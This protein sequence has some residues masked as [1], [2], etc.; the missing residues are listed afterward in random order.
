MGEAADN[1]RRYLVEVARFKARLDLRLPEGFH[2]HGAEDYLLD[3]GSPFESAPL[4]QEERAILDKAIERCPVARF[5]TGLCYFNAQMLVTADPT[6]TLI[7]CEGMAM[8]TVPVALNHGWAAI[9]G[10]VI[11]LTW[12]R[13]NGG[14]GKFKDRVL[15]AIPEGWA[16]YG[17][18]FD[19]ETVLTRMTRTGSV[20]CFLEDFANDFAIFREP[21][22]RSL[23]ELLQGEA[24]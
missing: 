21:R 12:R 10:K 11:D 17:A 23:A 15:G 9:N 2:Y 7:Y 16:Y 18:T 19:T 5:Q 1:L 20:G 4:T 8:G 14:R 13:V 3:R 22:I 24:T 6:R